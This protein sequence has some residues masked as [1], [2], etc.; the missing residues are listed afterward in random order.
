MS[1]SIARTTPVEQGFLC[2]VLP[3][4][5]LWQCTEQQPPLVGEFTILIGGAGT[6]RLNAATYGVN[7]DRPNAHCLLGI[8]TESGQ[9]EAHLNPSEKAP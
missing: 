2:P 1:P 9:P 7:P 3:P 8:S 5:S 4:E 6:T